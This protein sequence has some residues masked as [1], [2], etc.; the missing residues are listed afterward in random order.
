MTP[1][2]HCWIYSLSPAVPP[3]S[4]ASLPCASTVVGTA[5]IAVKPAKFFNQ[6]TTFRFIVAIYKAPT[7]FTSIH[8]I[9]LQLAIWN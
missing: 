6:T 7:L 5:I 2:N 4:A 3:A 1:S 8:F 9:L